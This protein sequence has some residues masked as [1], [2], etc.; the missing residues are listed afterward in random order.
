MSNKLA[1][2]GEPNPCPGCGTAQQYGGVDYFCPNKACKYDPLTKDKLKSCP[3]CHGTNAYSTEINEYS[4]EV[5]CPDCG[6]N[7]HQKSEDEARHLWNTR[8]PA[9]SLDALKRGEMAP[10]S[11]YTYETDYQMDKEFIRGWNHCV[12]QLAA[13]GLLNTAQTDAVDVKELR[14]EIVDKLF[15]ELVCEGGGPMYIAGKVLD[16]LTASG[17]RITKGE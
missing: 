13:H 10:K 17:Y 1:P 14:E 6:W 5:H 9:R 2:P 3:G 8:P 15:A 4:G 16:V 7:L 11:D 12:D